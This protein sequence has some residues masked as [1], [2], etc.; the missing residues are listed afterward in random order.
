MIHNLMKKPKIRFEAIV[1]F[2][3]MRWMKVLTFGSTLMI[4]EKVRKK[5]SKIDS[6]IRAFP[7]NNP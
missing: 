4:S 6:Y 5:N 7:Q 3:Q 1:N 2:I